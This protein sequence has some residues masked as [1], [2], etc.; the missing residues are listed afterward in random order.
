MRAVGV[1]LLGISLAFCCLSI[2]GCAAGTKDDGAGGGDT[3]GAGASGSTSAGS[4]SGAMASST[5]ALGTSATTGSGMPDPN[6]EVFGHSELTLY[7]LDPVT[8]AVTTIAPFSGCEGSVIDV[9]L[10]KD[11]NLFATSSGGLFR[12]DKDTAVC[13]L[14]S[15][16]PGYPNSLSFIP[17]GTLDPNEEALV[18]YA[19]DQYVRIDPVTGAITN[20]GSPWSNGLVSSGDIVSVKNGGTYLTVSGAECNDCLIEVNPATGA[21]IKNWGQLPYSGIWGIAFWAGS[22][23]GF[24]D[25][26][27]LFEVTFPNDTVMTTLIDSPPGVSFWGAGSTTSAPP[28]PQ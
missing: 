11:S 4:T 1:F 28:V 21:Q 18:G 16:G 15:E 7:K 13:T 3:A 22:V 9:A 8:K 17:A 19:G 5:G 27:Q 10:D 14:I 2:A 25:N 12:V 23:Y 6:A 26:G 20:V 24:T